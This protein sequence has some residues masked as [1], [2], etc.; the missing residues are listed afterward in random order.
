VNARTVFGGGLADD[1]RW[2]IPWWVATMLSL[3]GMNPY[4]KIAL[5]KLEMR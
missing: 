3:Y 4:D 2:K 1:R 5:S